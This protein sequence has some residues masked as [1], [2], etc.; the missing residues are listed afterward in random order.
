M[1]VDVVD[2][3]DAVGCDADS[4]V[5][6]DVVNVIDAVG[7]DVVNAIV[8]NDVVD[9]VIDGYKVSWYIV[10]TTIWIIK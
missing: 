2:V 3:V 10:S 9:V 1:D 5:D 7:C 4:S 6:F 8:D